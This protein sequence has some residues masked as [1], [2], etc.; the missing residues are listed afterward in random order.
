LRGSSRGPRSTREAA[1]VAVVIAADPQRRVYVRRIDVAGNTRTR[2]EVIRREFRQFESPRGTTARRSSC[3]ATGRPARLL[4][5][6]AVDTSEVPNAPD[7]VDL[8]VTVEEKPTGNLSVGANYSSAEQLTLSASI[9]QDN[10]F[11]SGNYLGI[12][13]QHRQEQPHLVLSTVD[14]YW[15]VDG[16]SRA[17]DLFYRTS[18]RST[19]RATTT[20]SPHLGRVGAFRRAV[21][22]LR[23]RV[24]RAGLRAA[25]TSPTI[26][27]CRTATSCIA[28][29]SA[30]PAIRCR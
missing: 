22:R 7:Q 25:R 11:G 13:H 19:A 1:Q 27:A 4:Q 8:L 14:P 16:I 30:R 24:L 12:E 29:S 9:Q 28:R 2:D 21:Q 17:F 15:T 26:A 20:R 23:H 18:A 5:G 10:V 6:R 3:R